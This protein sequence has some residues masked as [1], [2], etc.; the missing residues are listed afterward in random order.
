MSKTYFPTRKGSWDDVMWS[1]LL[2]NFTKK[3]KDAF[4]DKFG[5]DYLHS[6]GTSLKDFEKEQIDF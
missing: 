1:L 5:E 4:I 6:L 3:G 2:P